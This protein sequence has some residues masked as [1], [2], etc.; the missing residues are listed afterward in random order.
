MPHEQGPESGSVNAPARLTRRALLQR[1]G[2]LAFAAFSPL[3]CG[4][5]AQPNITVPIGGDARFLD[6]DELA[7]LRALVNRFIPGPPEDSAPGAAEAGCAEAID[8]LL[9]A[10]A[11]DPPRIYAGGPY[12]DR[13]GAATN[14][15]EHF[16]PLDDYEALAWRLRIE[17]SQGRPEREFNGPVRGLQTIYREG[18]AALDAQASTYGSDRFA[19]LPTVTA[20]LL[21]RTTRDAAVQ[22]LIDVAFPQ[23][24]ELM[25]GAPEYGGNRDLV[26]W[27]YTGFDGDVQPRG[28]TDEQ[29]EH[30]ENPGLSEWLPRLPVAIPLEQLIALTPLASYEG[31]QTILQN[32][33]GSLSRLTT[34]IAQVLAA[35]R[36]THGP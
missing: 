15:F 28:Y 8:A 19:D 2:L 27:Q 5:S 18:L 20:E 22:A 1:G 6:A 24:I 13:G 17:G 34:G 4:D 36:T 3:G 11:V 31:A 26:A 21:L 9:G 33:N 12:S 14:D 25:Y 16:I 7:A 32:S 35:R 23:T 29:V 10:F 30:P